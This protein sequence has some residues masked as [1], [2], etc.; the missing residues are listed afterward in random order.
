MKKLSLVAITIV[1]A[2]AVLISPL[3]YAQEQQQ[4]VYAELSDAQVELIR[5]NCLTVQVSLS[6]IHAN[7]GLLRVNLAQQY[8]AIASKLMAPMDSRISLNKLDGLAMATT[9]VEFNKQIKVFTDTYQKYEN[10]LSKSLTMRCG[11]QPIEFYDT[12]SLARSQRNQVNEEVKELNRL[13]R[14]Y[15][16]QYHAFKAGL[17]SN[18]GE[19]Q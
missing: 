7:D 15:I 13:V 1:A 9:T 10:T 19:S 5:K 6:R 11:D 16:E 3:A 17:K 4:P 18:G 14:Q 12:V 8:N 2:F